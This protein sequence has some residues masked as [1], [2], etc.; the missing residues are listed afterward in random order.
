MQKFE[1]N[2]KDS[3]FGSGRFVIR[4]GLVIRPVYP[5]FRKCPSIA[6]VFLKP[7]FQFSE[8]QILNEDVYK[9]RRFD[10]GIPEGPS[11]MAGELPLFMNGDIMNGIR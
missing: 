10:F 5:R 8:G 4:P 7:N 9:E 3:S 11:E 6:T 1:K 2:T